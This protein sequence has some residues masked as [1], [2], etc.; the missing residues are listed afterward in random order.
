MSRPLEYEGP[1]ESI[2]AVIE[3]TQK[4]MSVIG[5]RAGADRLE[6]W[7]DEINKALKEK[8]GVVITSNRTGMMKRVAVEELLETSGMEMVA[9][10][11]RE[12]KSEEVLKDYCKGAA[13]NNSIIVIDGIERLS[14]DEQEKVVEVL[15]KTGAKLIGLAS[16]V[17]SIPQPLKECT[18]IIDMNL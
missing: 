8:T 2:K 12:A 15:T 9:L 3:K 4:N 16:S 1:Q 18:E 6:S 17:K 10:R 14:R 5:S 13:K 11:L 7:R